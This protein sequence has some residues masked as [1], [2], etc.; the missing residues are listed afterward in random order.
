MLHFSFYLSFCHLL[1]FLIDNQCVT[2]GRCVVA[3]PASATRKFV[4][5]SPK[6]KSSDLPAVAEL[7]VQAP[8]TKSSKSVNWFWTCLDLML[9]GEKGGWG[10]V[11]AAGGKWVTDKKIF[12]TR[13]VLNTNPISMKGGKMT[14][15][16]WKQKLC[17][18]ETASIL[19]WDKIESSPHTCYV[20]ILTKQKR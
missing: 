10:R 18:R 3:D 11:V 20:E 9:M 13:N 19:C 16:T 7:F 4:P 2:G 15:K 14:N 6:Q 17:R 1:N 5:F 8:W 12:A